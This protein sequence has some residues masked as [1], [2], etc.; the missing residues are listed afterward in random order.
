M[1][2]IR[3]TARQNTFPT[4]EECQPIRVILAVKC[5]RQEIFGCWTI[6]D[7]LK[8]SPRSSKVWSE[9]TGNQPNTLINAPSQPII[10]WWSNHSNARSHELAKPT[11]DAPTFAAKIPKQFTSSR[12]QQ[13]QRTVVCCG[14]SK[15]SETA[16]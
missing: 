2:K 9:A 13:K 11:T 7:E 3:R 10:P 1:Y 6:P 8:F 12:Q 16:N 14:P 5:V 15:L 4:S